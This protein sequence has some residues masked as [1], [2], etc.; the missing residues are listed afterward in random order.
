MDNPRAES[1]CTPIDLGPLDERNLPTEADDVKGIVSPGHRDGQFA[2]LRVQVPIVASCSPPR[3]D[4]GCG[5]TSSRPR[6]A[7]LRAHLVRMFLVARRYHLHRI[8][9]PQR[10]PLLE[11]RRELAPLPCH[12]SV[13]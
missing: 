12:S 2:D 10:H 11:F 8:T 13:S 3:F 1:R 4:P 6:L 9:L 7:L 5:N